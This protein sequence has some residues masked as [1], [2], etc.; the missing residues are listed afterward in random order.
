MNFSANLK[1]LRTQS[2]LKQQDLAEI[3]HVSQQAIAKWENGKSEPN[4]S[5]LNDIAKVFDCSVTDLLGVEHS[6]KDEI[7][8]REDR[9]TIRDV[10]TLSIANF[11]KMCSEL[12]EDTLDR[13]HSLLYSIRRIQD[14]AVL[15]SSDK[16]F[17]LS[18]IAEIVGRIELY[19]DDF[20]YAENSD[21]TVD[22]PKRNRKFINTEV[23]VLK[24]ITN[25]ITPLKKPSTERHIVIPLYDTPASAGTGSWLADDMPREW[26][27]VSR[28]EKTSVADFILQVR[29]DSM[30]PKFSD[31]DYVL[32]KQ[33]IN[34]TEGE[35]C[36]FIL[37][38][39]SYIKKMGRG[40]LISLNPA[41]EPI[42]LNDFDDVRC[43]GKVIGTIEL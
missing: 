6:D 39:E 8:S 24:E 4:I 33:T 19:V 22:F 36:V 25:L 41:Y 16:Q 37:N 40:E 17:L 30:E 31:G 3:L 26:I 9:E 27:T 2:N 15:Y 14:N 32:V 28:D 23:E 38:N 20:R 43:A 42:K 12:D 35:I 1:K 10:H 21:V 11:E 7:L 34:I 18:C 5:M 29:G 13:I